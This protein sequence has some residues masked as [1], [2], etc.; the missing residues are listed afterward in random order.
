MDASVAGKV[1]STQM[2]SP[3]RVRIPPIRAGIHCVAFCNTQVLCEQV[4]DSGGTGIRISHVITPVT[5]T[6]SCSANTEKTLRSGR[7]RRIACGFARTT[8]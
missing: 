1:V 2:M 6:A 5:G 7:H 4:I 3:A 8:T